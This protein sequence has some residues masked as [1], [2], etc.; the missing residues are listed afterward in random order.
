MTV[1]SKPVGRTGETITRMEH[2]EQRQVA[3]HTV[4]TSL[5]SDVMRNRVSLAELRL[6]LIGEKTPIPATCP[7][8]FTMWDTRWIYGASSS[9]VR[10]M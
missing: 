7:T 10:G 9:Q 3:E 4:D 6:V 2:R 1:A 5:I 8:N